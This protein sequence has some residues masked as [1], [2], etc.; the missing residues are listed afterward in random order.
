MKILFL[1]L[2]L[3]FSAHVQAAAS[4]GKGGK[5]GF[6]SDSGHGNSGGGGGGSFSSTGRT[7]YRDS[8]SAPP[9]E[10]KRKVSEQDCS[11]PIDLTSGNLR[12]K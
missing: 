9:L 7:T 8:R 3:L 4:G 1:A 12:C 2:S 11:K 6:S 10:E 5:L